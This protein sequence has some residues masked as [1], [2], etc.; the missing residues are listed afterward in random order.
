MDTLVVTRVGNA[1]L[2]LVTAPSQD[3]SFNDDLILQPIEGSTC[4]EHV[5][6][7]PEKKILLVEFVGG[8][9][10][11]Y[12]DVPLNL[13]GRFLAAESKGT[14]YRENIRENFRVERIR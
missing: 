5:T 14:F 12:F 1:I 10:Y 9:W 11:R 4:I 3:E 6:Y 7:N 2:L 13:V 8:G